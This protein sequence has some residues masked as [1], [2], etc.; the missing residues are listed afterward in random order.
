M[1]VVAVVVVA[2][3]VVA[4][5]VVAAAAVVV[6]SFRSSSSFCSCS[7]LGCCWVDVHAW[8][9]CWFATCLFVERV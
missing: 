9:V 4:V 8:V 2:A 6:V 1:P 3:A 7:C 5:V